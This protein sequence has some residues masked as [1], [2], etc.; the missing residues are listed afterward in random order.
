MCNW[1]MHI[2]TLDDILRARDTIAPYINHTP[3]ISYN[4]LNKHV[5]VNIRLKHENHHSLGA[6]KIRGGINLLKNMSQAQKDRGVITVSTGNHGQSVATAASLTGINS[7]I[8]S[9]R[10]IS[11]GKICNST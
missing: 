8:V 11:K 9:P 4:A 3:L 7:I 5:G 6:F 10:N 2:P 1:S